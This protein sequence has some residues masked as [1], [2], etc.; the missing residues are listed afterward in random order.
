MIKSYEKN[1]IKIKT[2][3]LTQQLSNKSNQVSYSSCP[4]QQ[5]L[6]TQKS[7]K[8]RNPEPALQTP[9]DPTTATSTPTVHNHRITISQCYM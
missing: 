2:P 9:L 7:S 1:W 8:T 6:K 3:N 5:K 4:C